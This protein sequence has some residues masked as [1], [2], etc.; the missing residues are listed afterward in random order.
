MGADKELLNNHGL[1]ARQI[2]VQVAEK[3]AKE[4]GMQ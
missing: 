2:A 1:K 4:W 3:A